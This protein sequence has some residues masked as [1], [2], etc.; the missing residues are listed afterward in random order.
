[1]PRSERGSGVEGRSWSPSIAEETLATMPWA[2]F[3]KPKEHK[4]NKYTYAIVPVPIDRISSK[5]KFTPRR[6][7]LSRGGGDL[8]L[9][10]SGL[11]LIPYDITIP[12]SLITE[13]KT[14]TD[15][16]EYHTQVGCI[17]E[18]TKRDILSADSKSYYSPGI[19]EDEKIIA[20]SLGDRNLTPQ[21][22]LNNTEEG[23]YNRVK[24]NDCNYLRVTGLYFNAQFEPYE[25]NEVYQA[26]LKRQSDF[27]KPLVVLNKPL[28][29]FS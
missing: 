27:N 23:S 7:V 18:P 14:P 9:R 4:D 19:T 10:N 1:M 17:F 28:V 22:L 16:N 11:P 24:L 20:S 8:Y 5:E 29:D 26:M 25:S 3:T 2:D 21:Q 12:P 13:E 15:V 6:M